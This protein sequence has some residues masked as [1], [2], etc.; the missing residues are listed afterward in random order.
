MSHP[1]LSRSHCVGTMRVI[2]HFVRPSSPEYVTN[3]GAWNNVHST[4]TQPHPVKGMASL[5]LIFCQKR[6]EV[7][8]TD[9]KAFYLQLIKTQWVILA[10]CLRRI[11]APPLPLF[12]RKLILM[13]YE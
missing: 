9:S 13:E 10:I 7:T 5:Y 4:M 3:L 8:F 6:T 11:K 12:F 2:W 1:D